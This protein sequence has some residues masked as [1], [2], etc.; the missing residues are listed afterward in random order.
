[1]VGLD[2][3]QKIE[4]TG[5]TSVWSV[6]VSYVKKKYLV[7]IKFLLIILMKFQKDTVLLVIYL[8]F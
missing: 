1:M 3:L 6:F 2:D 5:V 7:Q 8:S 4:N